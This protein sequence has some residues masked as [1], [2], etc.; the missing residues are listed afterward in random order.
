MFLPSDIKPKPNYLLYVGQK[1]SHRQYTHLSRISYEGM[2][3]QK[4]DC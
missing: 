4:N 3:L 1:T 2:D